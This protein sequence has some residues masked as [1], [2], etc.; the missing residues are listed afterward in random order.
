MT[1]VRWRTLAAQRGG[2]LNGSYD[3]ITS[4]LGVC[5]S[6]TAVG[7]LRYRSRLTP[8]RRGHWAIAGW[9]ALASAMT[10][11]VLWHG[12]VIG[13]FAALLTF[14]LS[15]LL[16]VFL[17]AEV[18]MGRARPPRLTEPESRPNRRWRGWARGATA[19][20]LAMFA[21]VAIGAVFA[22]FPIGTPADRVAVGLLVVPFLWAA[23]V[24]W[25]LAD[26]KILRPVM[27]MTSALALSGA[28][29]AWG[30]LA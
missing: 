23:F 11:L 2:A 3:V 24:V 19:F 28:A 29:I 9:L 5:A 16:A 12:V 1:T 30:L 6:V 10:L 27:G 7:L 22:G 25:A 26:Q 17:D 21:S 4:A 18:R 15:G 13:I 20:L 8:D 14:S